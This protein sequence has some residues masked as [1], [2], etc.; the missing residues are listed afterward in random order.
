MSGL[1]RTVTLLATA[2]VRID[3]RALDDGRVVFAGSDV[4][5]GMRGYDYELAIPAAAVP[6]LIA[7]LGGAPGS[8][9][10]EV[11]EANKDALL[12]AGEVAWCRAHG[13]E[14]DFSSRMR[15]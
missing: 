2:G 6:T 3:V 12:E 15:S 4:S 8:D 14:A 9:P 13:V 11:V 7:E 10:L 1:P 5:V